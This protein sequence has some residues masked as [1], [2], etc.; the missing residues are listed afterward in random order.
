MREWSEKHIR[1][2]IDNEYK[3]LAG[4]GGL[5]FDSLMKRIYDELER[6]LKT[7]KP[8]DLL[9]RLQ[10]INSEAP[11]MYYYLDAIDI[12]RYPPSGTWAK[13]QPITVTYS[14]HISSTRYRGSHTATTPMPM[15]LG[16]YVLVNDTN[17]G[18]ALE[19]AAPEHISEF[20]AT[21][22][23][24]QDT[25]GLRYGTPMGSYGYY[26]P[27]QYP[28]TAQYIQIDQLN[29]VPKGGV[30][31]SYGA[32]SPGVKNIYTTVPIAYNT[33]LTSEPVAFTMDLNFDQIA[34]PMLSVYDVLQQ[35][36]K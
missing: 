11:I 17:V 36:L 10:P 27:A 21:L 23:V 8:G 19:L 20:I 16:T 24:Y 35:A 7:I 12:T 30:V 29:F 34:V 2:M 1:E 5:D 33:I 14:Y 6:R 26:N 22:G 3:R 4:T 18:V 13:Q 31:E 25:I 28:S 32:S 9:G 15:Y